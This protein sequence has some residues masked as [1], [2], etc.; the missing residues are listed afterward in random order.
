MR[1]FGFFAFG[2]LT[3]LLVLKLIDRAYARGPH[4]ETDRL[5]ENILDRLDELE[6]RLARA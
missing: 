6:G 5:T 2:V 1:A 4:E 3:G